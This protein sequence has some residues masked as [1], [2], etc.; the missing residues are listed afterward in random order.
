MQ[1]WHTQ[2][3]DHLRSLRSNKPVKSDFVTEAILNA[4]IIRISTLISAEVNQTKLKITTEYLVIEKGKK[5]VDEV[6]GKQE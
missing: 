2:K 3:I 1:N 5:I 6:V 4:K